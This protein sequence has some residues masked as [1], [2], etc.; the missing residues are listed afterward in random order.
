MP[1][2]V[3]GKCSRGSLYGSPRPQIEAAPVPGTANVS[4]ELRAL[5]AQLSEAET[6]WSY[7][8]RDE[9]VARRAERRIGLMLDDW[10]KSWARR[11]NN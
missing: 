5:I 8:A 2:A 9:L 10:D 7:Q 6:E 11:Q 4:R 3:P 1:P